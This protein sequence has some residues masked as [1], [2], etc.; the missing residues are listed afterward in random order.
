MNNFTLGFIAGAVT[1]LALAIVLARLSG[2]VR[3]LSGLFGRD[4]I[5]KRLRDA[6]KERDKALDEAQALSKRLTEKDELIK[7]AMASLTKPPNS[8]REN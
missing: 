2:G 5:Q 4:P 8:T 3:W 1:G 6:E 7:K